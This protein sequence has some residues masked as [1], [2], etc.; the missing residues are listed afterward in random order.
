MRLI[1]TLEDERLGLA[2]SNFLNKKGISHQLEMNPDR[3]WGSPNYGTTKCL[4][5][6]TEED[7]MDEAVSWLN[8]FQENPYDPQFDLSQSNQAPVSMQKQPPQNPQI[9]STAVDTPL[10]PITRFLL[11]GCC[12]LFFI[13][14]LLTPSTNLPANVTASPLFS[15]PIEKEILYDYPAVYQLID[16]LVKTYGYEALQE[17]STLPPEGHKLIDQINRTPYW[18]GAYEIIQKDGFKALPKKIH[19]TPMFEKIQ[20]GQVWRLVTPIFFHA[21]LL[22]L[23]FNMLWLL[24]L[25][26]EIEIRLGPWRYIFFI[27]LIGVFSNTCQYLMGGANFI[28]F[29]GVLCGML[30][31]IWIRQKR[32]AWEGYRLERMTILFMLLYIFAMA[33]IQFFSFVLEKTLDVSI[34]PGIAN[35]AHLSGAFMGVVLGFLNIFSW[36]PSK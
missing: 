15:S 12:L 7:Q 2:F 9:N 36:R 24:V 28:G 1:G 14:Q 35:T 26:K 19:S 32:A 30:T 11:I 25:G 33:G 20:Q 5:W 34:S 17:P 3:D 31:F 27:L 23:F 21:N 10:G 8:L 18:Q 22:H 13:A 16:H 4:I 29:S 6:I